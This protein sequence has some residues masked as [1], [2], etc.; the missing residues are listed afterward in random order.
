VGRWPAQAIRLLPEHCGLTLGDIGCLE[1]KMVQG[2]QTLAVAIAHD[3][4]FHTLIVNG[5]AIALGHPPAAEGVRLTLNPARQMQRRGVGC[6]IAPPGVG[7]RQAIALLLQNPDMRE[8]FRKKS[9]SGINS[10]SGPMDSGVKSY[11][12]NSK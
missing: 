12:N 9:F 1:I 2:A 10:V 5:G 7:G 11:S 8:T 6:R 3:P 4:D